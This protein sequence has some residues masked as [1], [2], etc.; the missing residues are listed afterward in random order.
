MTLGEKG[1]EQVSRR[2]GN[3]GDAGEASTSVMCW[4]LFKRFTRAALATVPP[5]KLIRTELNE[6]RSTSSGV[7]ERHQR[8]SREEMGQGGRTEQAGDVD[9]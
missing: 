1:Y 5:H 2:Y 4:W 6:E 3:H 9:T 7:Y 8:R